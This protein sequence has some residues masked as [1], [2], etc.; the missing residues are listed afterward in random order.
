[1]R[2]V[3]VNC[4]PLGTMAYKDMGFPGIEFLRRVLHSHNRF[5]TDCMAKAPV[6]GFKLERAARKLGF[7]RIA[8]LDEVGRGCFLL[9]VGIRLCQSRGNSAAPGSTC[10][11][12]CTKA[13]LN[14]LGGT[15]VKVPGN[16]GRQLPARSIVRPCQLGLSVQ[17]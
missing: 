1:M 9:V 3:T 12:R 5:Y 14:E 4:S 10:P 13:R 15:V 6:C 2:S 17:V 7:L 11:I 16:A 8:G